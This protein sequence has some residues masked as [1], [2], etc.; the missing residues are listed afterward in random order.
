MTRNTNNITS[1]ACRYCQA[2][3]SKQSIKGDFVYGGQPHQKFWQCAH[4]QMIYLFPPLTEKEEIAFYRKEF[5]QYMEKRGAKDKDWSS[6]EKH[7]QSN[8]TEM[9][10]RMQILDMYL[11]K[12]QK[13]LEIGC[14]SGFVL[15]ALRERGHEVVGLDPSEV[16]IDYVRAKNIQVYKD[17]KDL[18]K[19]N[20]GLFDCI[21]HYY[22]LEHIRD[23]VDFVSAYMKLLRPEGIMVFEVPCATDPLVELYK[24][25]AFDKFYWSVAHHWYFNRESIANLLDKTGYPYE[26][27]PEQRYD[28]S[29][30]MVWMLEGKPG[31]YGRFSDVFGP[32]LDTMYKEKLKANW[33]CD[34][35]VAVV[36]NPPH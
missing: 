29:N 33:L 25:P 5:E 3:S 17:L 19:N 1:P 31:G 7:F 24:V 34:T 30:H 22:V 13:I 32:E 11:L 9:K 14:S 36:K 2:D 12:R 27:L 28:I 26:L 4:C 8:R 10:R 18:K 23:P 15:H 21:I 16:F 6:P 20:H 35:I